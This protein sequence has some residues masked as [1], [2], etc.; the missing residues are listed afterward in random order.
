MWT[1]ELGLGR[2]VCRGGSCSPSWTPC[3]YVEVKN[4]RKGHHNY[5]LIQFILKT[6]YVDI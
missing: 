5:L 1:V 3:G 4:P 2:Q 6:N